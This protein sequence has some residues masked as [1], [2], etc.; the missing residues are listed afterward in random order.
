MAEN[1]TN[2]NQRE[3]ACTALGCLEAAIAVPALIRRLSDTDIWVRAKA[4]KALGQVDTRR[5]RPCPPCWGC[6]H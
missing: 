4:A 1:P 3:A 2:A 5:P 6:C